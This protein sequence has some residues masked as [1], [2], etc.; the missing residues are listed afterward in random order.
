MVDRA[1]EWSAFRQQVRNVRFTVVAAIDG[2][3]RF[4]IAELKTG[5]R[6]IVQSFTNQFDGSFHHQVC[7]FGNQFLLSLVDQIIVDQVVS[8]TRTTVIVRKRKHDLRT[9]QVELLFGFLEDAVA[10]NLWDAL[11]VAGNQNHAIS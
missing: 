9:R 8:Q 10:H 1:D 3:G 11:E 6:Q 2:K 5:G 7:V 4:A